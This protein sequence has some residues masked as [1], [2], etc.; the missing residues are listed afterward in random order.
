[1][2]ARNWRKTQALLAHLG[3]TFPN[4]FGLAVGGLTAGLVVLQ[5]ANAAALRAFWPFYCALGFNVLVASLV[6]G[7]LLFRG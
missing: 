7:R 4:S 6:F 3:T 1:M 5:A 2:L